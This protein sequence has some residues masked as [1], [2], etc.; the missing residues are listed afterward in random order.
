MLKDNPDYIDEVLPRA[1]LFGVETNFLQA[2]EQ[3]IQ[4]PYQPEWYTG[5]T[6]FSTIVLHNL[7]SQ[8]QSATTPPSSSGFSVSGGG[9]SSG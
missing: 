4:K 6:L 5:D 3:V 7:S 8:I 9:G 1:V 2:I